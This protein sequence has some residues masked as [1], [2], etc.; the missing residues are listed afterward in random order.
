VQQRCQQ[1]RNRGATEVQLSELSK[2][3]SAT[4]VQQRCQ[5]RRNRGANSGAAEAQQR[6]G[7]CE[8]QVIEHTH[9]GLC[10]TYVAP[11]LHLYYLLREASNRAH[12]SIGSQR[13]A[14]CRKFNV[15]LTQI[16]GS[17]YSRDSS[18]MN[19]WAWEAQ[20]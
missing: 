12:T 3:N 13:I 14:N 19:H 2:D 18:L 17:K 20:R 10:C 7:C 11:L 9:S 4:N 8:K 15:K 1:R 6:R 16:A 5:Q